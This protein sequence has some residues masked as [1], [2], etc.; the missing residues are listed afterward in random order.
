MNLPEVKLT[1][2][3]NRQ[4]LTAQIMDHLGNEADYIAAEIE[5]GVK[6]AVEAINVRDRAKDIALKAME[7]EL[8]SY[9]KYG[10]GAT[11]IRDALKVSLSHSVNI[12]KEPGK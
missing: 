1:I 10:D 12:D 6:D 3:I 7:R 2:D 4:R 9:F 5:K 11:A 8:E